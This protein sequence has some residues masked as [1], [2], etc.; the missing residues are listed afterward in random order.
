MAF[1][2]NAT[3]FPPEQAGMPPELAGIFGG[4]GGPPAGPPAPETDVSDP[5]ELVRQIMRDALSPVDA[6]EEASIANIVAKFQQLIA[7]QA[8]EADTAMGVGPAQKFMRRQAAAG[9]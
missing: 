9:G 4:L 8:K 7:A 3:P 6:N 5:V 2:P 1:D